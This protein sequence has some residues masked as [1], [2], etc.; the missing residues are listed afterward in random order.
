MGKLMHLFDDLKERYNAA[1]WWGKLLWI[2]PLILVGALA[3]IAAFGSKGNLPDPKRTELEDKANEVLVDNTITKK[4][5][6]KDQ[7][8]KAAE[9][10]FLEEKQK[11]LDK[12]TAKT[13]ATIKEVKDAET[14]AELRKIQERME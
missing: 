7:Q 13:E 9:K 1:P 5:I 4:E 2:L 8:Q 11:L 14:I 12:D 6:E 10:L 3:L